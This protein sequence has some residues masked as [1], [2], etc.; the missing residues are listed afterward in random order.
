MRIV[1]LFAALILA[2][3]LAA[4]ER[5][6]LLK[7]FEPQATGTSLPQAY[8]VPTENPGPQKDI[9]ATRIQDLPRSP[10]GTEHEGY[11]RF[12]Q[13]LNRQDPPPFLGQSRH[14]VAAYVTADDTHILTRTWQDGSELYLL[15]GRFA[16]TYQTG[17][18]IKLTFPI[19]PGGISAGDTDDHRPSDTSLAELSDGS[20]LLSL[21]TL[22]RCSGTRRYGVMI[23]LAPD[24]QS[25]MWVSPQRV[26]GGRGFAFNEARVF[27]IDGG[28]CEKDYLYELDI[29]SGQVAS[30][31][32]VPSAQD[33]GDFTTMHGK[34]LYLQLYN[35]FI[36]YQLP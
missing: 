36:H 5:S 31:T 22:N 26:A 24:L 2:A 15:V 29:D 13:T 33:A 12:R 4:Q 16:P 34:D 30:R 32:V 23:R 17:Q 6:P 35:R 25:V 14:E 8:V 3:P 20:L 11:N 10:V 28:S 18:A 9:R 27:A 7:A 19:G 21:D 1:S